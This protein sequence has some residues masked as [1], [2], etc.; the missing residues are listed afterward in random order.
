VFMSGVMIAAQRLGLMGEMPPEKITARLLDRAGWKS[1]S[2]RSQDLL[3]ALLHLGFGGAG[4][5][6]FALAERRPHPPLPTVPA[7]ILF[8]C[9]VWLVS[10][11]GWVPALRIMAPPSRDRPGRPQAMLAAHLVYGAVLGAIVGCTGQR[12]RGPNRPSTKVSG[13]RPGTR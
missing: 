4:G 2:R 13:T 6:L 10:Y 11:Q 12:A 8:G 9:A 3:S 1:R 7:G 5:A